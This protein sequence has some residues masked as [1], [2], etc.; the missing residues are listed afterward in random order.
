MASQN[1]RAREAERIERLAR[2]IAG[3]SQDPIVL[4][5]ARSAAAAEFDMARGRQASNALIVRV[6]SL[7]TLEPPRYFRTWQDELR[8]LLAQTYVGELERCGKRPAVPPLPPP[9]P[10]NPAGP[11][12]TGDLECTVESVRRI[13][14]ELHRIYRSEQRAAARRDSAIRQIGEHLRDTK[15]S[16]LH[17]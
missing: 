12:L 16:T 6:R 4:E 11:M 3:D 15:R 7:G 17:N 10:L 9:E 5:L 8:W 14:P 1:L 2:Q 13:L